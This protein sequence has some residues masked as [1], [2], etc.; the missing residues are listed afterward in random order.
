MIIK[1]VIIV[2]VVVIVVVVVVVVT[3]AAVTVLLRL[4]PSSRPNP[5][6]TSLV[7]GSIN[8]LASVA[9]HLNTCMKAKVSLFCFHNSNERE[10]L[11]WRF[12]DTQPGGKKMVV[13]VVMPKRAQL[14]LPT[15]TI[16]FA[17]AAATAIPIKSTTATC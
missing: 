13:V 1:V 17:T 16:S 6:T 12:I 14:F 9:E 10:P 3:A 8:C 11:D 15:A 2:I 5:P 4:V 7:L